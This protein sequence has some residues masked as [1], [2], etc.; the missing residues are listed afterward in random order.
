MENRYKKALKN[1]KKLKPTKKEE[2]DIKAQ[3]QKALELA[4]EYDLFTDYEDDK[5]RAEVAFHTFLFDSMNETEVEIQKNKNDRLGLATIIGLGVTMEAGLTAIM[6]LIPKGKGIASILGFTVGSGIVAGVIAFLLIPQRL[7]DS[8]L[9]NDDFI[10]FRLLEAPFEY[11]G[12]LYAHNNFE[13]FY[14]RGENSRKMLRDIV[15]IEYY[16]ARNPSV[17][18]MKYRIL[19][20]TDYWKR[21]YYKDRERYLSEFAQI[22]REQASQ[23]EMPFY[24]P[25]WER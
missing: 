16:I 7:G 17:E 5:E 24:K 22:L 25:E 14:M 4:K 15:D 19:P 23:Y 6:F 10:P 20:Y 21:M 2:K 1:Y 3:K 13:T 8:I 12:K 9:P 11:V 18:N